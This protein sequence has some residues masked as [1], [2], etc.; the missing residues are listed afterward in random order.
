MVSWRVSSGR[1][2]MEGFGWAGDMH[3]YALR[4][5]ATMKQPCPAWH[6]H[7]ALQTADAYDCFSRGIWEYRWCCFSCM[8]C[9]ASMYEWAPAR[10]IHDLP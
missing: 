4:T 5:F 3:A 6:V 10:H 1:R 8:L 9:Q 2:T 7:A